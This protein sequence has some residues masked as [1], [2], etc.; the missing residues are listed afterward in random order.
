MNHRALNTKFTRPGIIV[1]LLLSIFC[2]LSAQVEE[3]TQASIYAEKARD[4]KNKREFDSAEY[5][6]S[7]AITF[8]NSE[9]LKTASYQMDLASLYMGYGKFPSAR[10]MLE[11][12]KKNIN[13]TSIQSQEVFDTRAYYYNRLGIYHS[14]L[15]RFDSCI[16]SH[17][18]E[19]AIYKESPKFDSLLYATA[20]SNLA[21]AHANTN[22]IET[23][24]AYV[25]ESYA[26]K[27]KLLGPN[28]P[29]LVVTYLL[30]GT[31][32]IE[33]SHSIEEALNYLEEAHRIALATSGPESQ[34]ALQA[35]Q[36]LGFGYGT[37]REN[38]KAIAVLS[39][40]LDLSLRIMGGANIY[41]VQLYN[42][43]A[44]ALTDLGRYDEAIEYYRQYELVSQQ[45]QGDIRNN[46]AATFMGLGIIYLQTKNFE[47]A[48]EYLLKAQVLFQG[49]FGSKHPSLATINIQLSKIYHEE[50]DTEKALILAE[51]AIDIS[52]YNSEALRDN[53]MPLNWRAEYPIEYTTSYLLKTQ[54]LL[55]QE[56]EGEANSDG[57]ETFRLTEKLLENGLT[58]Q[59]KIGDINTLQR[60]SNHLYANGINTLWR[61]DSIS[62]KPGSFEEM[63]SYSE[64]AKAIHQLLKERKRQVSNM[65][66]IPLEI[67]AEETDINRQITRYKSLMIAQGRTDSIQAKLFE[68]RQQKIDF[69]ER[70]KSDFPKNH[71][72][73]FNINRIKPEDVL[74]KLNIDQTIIDYFVADNSV[75]AFVISKEGI[76]S[77]RL[78]THSEITHQIETLANS[79]TQ[80]KG[81]SFVQPA[82]ELFKMIFEP[83]TDHLSGNDLVIIPDK[84]L[85][86]INFDLLLSSSP[87][88]TDYAK[89]DYLL[90]KYR[91][92]Y[93]NS[94]SLLF[95][96]MNRK[97]TQKNLLAL[98]FGPNE[99]KD[100][101]LKN[102]RDSPKENLPGT[103]AEVR[104]LSS[105]INGDFYYG[106]EA[107][108]S[109]FK[110]S[111]P[112]YS[113]LHLA[114]HGEVDE[115]NPDN[116]KLYFTPDT[117]SKVEDNT[118]HTFELYHMEL[119][120]EL[121]VLSACN[122]G[123]GNIKNGEGIMSLGK[124]FQYA[125]VKSVL[126]SQW[127]VSDAI[128]PVIMSS[129]YNNLKEG[130]SKSE[131]L[132]QAKLD[133]L[134]SS[135][136]ITS[137][138]YYWGSFFIVGNPDPINLN[139]KSN[140]WYWIVGLLMLVVLIIYRKKIGVKTTA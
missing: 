34:Q 119:N 140:Q 2:S 63:W 16:I 78:G 137:N 125:G 118:L 111:A 22:D 6:F 74:A 87:S 25:E 62:H 126:L 79:L 24:F 66:D 31:H 59:S 65:G 123:S 58:G 49:L 112:D 51:K 77:F 39:P 88:S 113:V 45:V 109:A 9:P 70:I 104:N 120:A 108:E 50:G 68:L 4:F 54:L 138:P 3:N 21:A 20:L 61:Q 83:L 100:T 69:E 32:L 29:D 71:A 8:S 80:D 122:T 90:K 99:Q 101:D 132:R 116:S 103:A 64:K 40:A 110:K 81:I 27:R 5:F 94:V 14:I 114:L 35:M 33:S 56:I 42:E 48:E 36:V 30:L 38:E 73:M 117:T 84:N 107:N 44:R 91:I 102:F 19:I 26:I 60:L 86:N 41:N 134:E 43:I 17:E 106:H 97:S 37:A 136:N 129:F 55:D 82:Y 133:F 76:K 130:K 131:S 127:E 72:L 75:F 10:N 52:S 53:N 121:A 46:D 139:P 95:K 115:E 105:S 135:N 12:S 85:W 92:S 15:G 67:L 13:T 98:A 1:F 93:A 18:N 124:A 23:S 28:H 11:L 128:A 96:D 57:W 47:L 7:K 89:H